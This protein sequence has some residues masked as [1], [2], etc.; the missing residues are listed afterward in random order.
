MHP[1]NQAVGSK[2]VPTRPLYC[3]FVR[4]LRNVVSRVE[5]T[6]PVAR[7]FVFVGLQPHTKTWSSQNKKRHNPKELG[8]QRILSHRK[9]ELQELRP[10][11]HENLL[12]PE[13]QNLH[14][15]R[16]LPLFLGFPHPPQSV[17]L[18]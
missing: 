9:A 2:Y 3:I 8:V 18:V 4:A 10:F 15:F 11:V 16:L 17:G 1:Q 12:V 14:P 7:T 6:N 5:W 13:L